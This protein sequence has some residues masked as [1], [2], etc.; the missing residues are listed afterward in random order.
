MTSCCLCGHRKQKCHRPKK[1]KKNGGRCPLSTSGH[2]CVH[3]T[4]I[5]SVGVSCRQRGSSCRSWGGPWSS[6]RHQ[7]QLDTSRGGQDVLKSS[8]S[9]WKSRSDSVSCPQLI[10]MTLNMVNGIK[11]DGA[12]GSTLWWWGTVRKQAPLSFIFIRISCLIGSFAFDWTG[13]WVGRN[14]CCFC[15]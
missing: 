10:C 15:S 7:T 1:E 11:W 14:W 8:C 9:R 3:E 13:G 6:T 5:Q 2:L 12:V 4:G